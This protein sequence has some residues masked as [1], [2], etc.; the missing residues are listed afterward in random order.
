MTTLYR[1]PSPGGDEDEGEWV[2]VVHDCR[3]PSEAQ[4]R[5][6]QATHG[7][8]W[9]CGHCKV[10]WKLDMNKKNQRHLVGSPRKEGLEGLQNLFAAPEP[11]A[12]RWIRIAPVPD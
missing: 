11:P 10:K 4:I 6:K 12:L 2:T 1:E 5:E 8:V 3:P 7:T 9:A